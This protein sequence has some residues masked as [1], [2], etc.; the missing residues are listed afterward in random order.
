MTASGPLTPPSDE[1]PAVD[2]TQGFRET[3]TGTTED[4]ADSLLHKQLQHIEALAALRGTDAYN[5][6]RRS[7]FSE[8][9]GLAPCGFNGGA[10]SQL[11]A[12]L[13]VNK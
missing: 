12:R 5:A 4:C 10:L 8:P 3:R 1:A 11:P 13:G 2:A 7:T 9:Q 6:K